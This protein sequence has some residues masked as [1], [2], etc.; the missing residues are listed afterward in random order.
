MLD[1]GSFGGS[2]SPYRH[3]AQLSNAEGGG[4]NPIPPARSS[5]AV[6]PFAFV[7]ALAVELSFVLGIVVLAKVS[8]GHAVDAAASTTAVSVAGFYSRNTI[9]TIWARLIGAAGPD[10]Q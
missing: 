3:D 7:A 5:C 1:A 2:T 10:K 9:G 6:N 8:P 4:G